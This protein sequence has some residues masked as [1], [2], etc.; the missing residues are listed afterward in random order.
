[1]S[2]IDLKPETC[3]LK[4]MPF[5][6]GQE[7]EIS[8]LVYS[9]ID[10][11]IAP[12]YGRKVVDLLKRKYASKEILKRLENPNF[13]IWYVMH[14]GEIRWVTGLEK[15]EQEIE[16][17]MFYGKNNGAR[18]AHE[19]LEKAREELYSN[20]LEF[21]SGKVLKTAQCF[22]Q[23]VVEKKARKLSFEEKIV[24]ETDVETGEKVHFSIVEYRFWPR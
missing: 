10:A 6:Q 17:S 8:Q 12:A 23:K 22:I 4:V 2:V 5:Y 15:K 18:A 1:M 24:E 3:R 21:I 13:N 19:L 11:N 7:I 20:G 9:C 14:N 16:L